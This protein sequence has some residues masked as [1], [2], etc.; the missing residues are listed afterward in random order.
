L[1][2]AQFR[3]AFVAYPKISL[4]IDQAMQ[5]VMSGQS[6]AQAMST[7][8]QQVVNIAGASNVEPGT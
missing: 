3:P 4:Q 5:N 2:F 7:F 6:P 8:A 1:S